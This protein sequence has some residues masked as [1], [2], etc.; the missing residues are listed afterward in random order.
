MVTAKLMPN[1]YCGY[2]KGC[3]YWLL[4]LNI[5]LSGKT[6]NDRFRLKVKMLKFLDDLHLSLPR[7]CLG[8]C[9]RNAKKVNNDEKLG[10]EKH[11]HKKLWLL[12]NSTS[13]FACRALYPLTCSNCDFLWNVA[14]ITLPYHIVQYRDHESLGFWPKIITPKP[15]WHLLSD[16]LRVL[17]RYSQ[18]QK[19]L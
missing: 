3:L 18:A 15:A 11:Q 2:C 17:V 7:S 1:A 4:W 9:F 16:S 10:F 12:K 13:N 5:C 19:C 14:F 6:N 8:A